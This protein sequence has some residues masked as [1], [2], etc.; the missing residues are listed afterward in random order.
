MRGRN[1]R[2]TFPKAKLL[3]LAESMKTR[4]EIFDSIALAYRAALRAAGEDELVVAAGSFATIRECMQEIGW[5]SVE[6]GRPQIG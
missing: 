5:E 2:A 4:P 6:D 1:K 3:E